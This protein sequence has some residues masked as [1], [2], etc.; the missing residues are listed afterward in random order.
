MSFPK[1]LDELK[2]LRQWVAYRLVWNAKKGKADKRPINPHDGTGAKANDPTTWG[3]YDEATQYALKNGLVGNV[4]GIGFEFASGYA[5]IDLDD[6]VEAGGILKPFAGEIVGLM[7]SYTEYSPSHKGV[8]ILC[9]L[10]VSMSEFG[11]RRR[12][13]EIGLEMYDSGRFFTVTGEIFGEEA[14]AIENRTEEARKVY[15]KYLHNEKAK[16]S[17]MGLLRS[18]EGVFQ[19]ELTDRELWDKMFDS[20][21]GREILALYQGDTSGYGDDHSRADLALCSHLAYWTNSDELRMDRMFRES[22]L[23]RGKWDERHGGQTYGAM[24]LG[25]AMRTV[26]SSYTP[27]VYPIC[28]VRVTGDKSSGFMNVRN[29][30]SKIPERAEM[31]QRSEMRSISEKRP[32]VRFVDEYLGSRFMTDME[33]YSKY[34]DRKTGYSNLD[35]KMSLYPGLYVLGAVSSLGKTTFVGQLADQLS[36]AGDRVLYFAL[37]QSEFELVSKGISRQTARKDM[38]TAVSAMQIRN[39]YR[40]EGVK[41]AMEVYR[42]IACNEAIIECGFDT[43]IETITDTVQEYISQTGNRPVVIVDYLQI[44][45]PLDS[46]QSTKDAVDGHVR[47]F[48]KLQVE[49]DLVVILISSLNR[50]NYLTPVDFESF[51]E[52]GG[53]EYTADVIWGLQLSIMND[54]MFDK[55]KGLKQKR[56]AVRTAK[57]ENPR[58]IELVCLKNRYGISSYRCEFLYYARYDL[59][60]PMKVEGEEKKRRVI[61]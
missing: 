41:E 8:H 14:K 9:K 31:I 37:E 54:E 15:D 4:G 22:G 59:F 61:L 16:I 47:A 17:N 18:L 38:E 44:I 6:V 34:R 1:Q 26:T 32:M 25:L 5:G 21:H 55:E 46:R 51:K 49:N 48:K 57:N 19:S 2:P 12:N 43:T 36:E 53:I 28:E 27:S 13:D 3:T 10:S 60:V 11:T 50:Q 33:R 52:S 45:R 42:S 20:Q 7:G 40:T 24:T 35:E 39:G 58:K 23:M 56:E 30:Y 29:L